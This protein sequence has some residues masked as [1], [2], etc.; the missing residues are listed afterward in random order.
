[1][2]TIRDVARAAGVS[3]ATVSRSLNEAELVTDETRRKVLT[4]IDNLGY[5]PNAVA[6]GLTTRKTKTIGLVVS[7]ITNPFYP[8]VARGVEDVVSAYGYNIILCNTDRDAKKELAYI[9]LLI[10]KRVEGIVFASVPADQTLLADLD[11]SGVPWVAAGNAVGGLDHDCVVVDN[12]LGA[13]QATQHLI[14]LG[15]RR[16]GHITGPANETVTKERIEGFRQ[17]LVNQGF[18][19][20]MSPVVEADF[21]QAGG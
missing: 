21:R 18:D 6:R 8:E 10:E 13:Y 2:V 5:R 1:M 16:V 19:P 11:R 3:T 15:H 20:G 4:A 9:N 7:D 14:R 12:I 17:A